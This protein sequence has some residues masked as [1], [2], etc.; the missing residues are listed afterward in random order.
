MKRVRIVVLGVVAI[1]ALHAPARAEDPK[2]DAITVTPWSGASLDFTSEEKRATLEYMQTLLDRAQVYLKVSAP[3]DED[4]RLA[5]FTN[6]NR[7]VGGFAADLQIG[8]DER[9][10]YLGELAELLEKLGKLRDRLAALP[11]SSQSGAIA[12]ILAKWGNNDGQ[13]IRGLCREAG[14]ACESPFDA[15]KRKKLWEFVCRR[16][17]G[18]EVCAGDEPKIAER[19]RDKAAECVG[20]PGPSEACALATWMVDVIERTRMAEEAFGLVDR[21]EP[22]GDDLWSTIQRYDKETAAH[23]RK[24]LNLG[25]DTTP[26]VAQLVPYAAALAATVNRLLRQ[27]ALARRDALVTGGTGGADR[28]FAAIALDVAVAYDRAS[29]YQD[30]FDADPAL[31]SKYDVSFGVNGTYYG[32]GGWTVNGRAGYELSRDPGAVP[33]KRCEPVGTAG[34]AASGEACADALFR[35]GPEPEAEGS[36]YLRLAIGYQYPGASA[37]AKFVPGIEL[38]GGLSDI[39]REGAD[40]T[41]ELRLTL[42]GTPV[43]GDKAARVGVALDAARTEGTGCIVTPIVFVGATTSTLM[44]H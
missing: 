13:M 5:A 15:A 14:L 23:I 34:G 4:T 31:M 39:G 44:A 3:L 20:C 8:Y 28:G 19:A 30:D 38:R 7:L 25:P 42:F 9:A 1:V 6:Q 17:L 29:V 26:T 33:F 22:H 41:W 11:A 10:K 18:A 40:R 27:S 36:A 24:E 12:D 43:E 16:Y 37:D 21:L 2:K 35:A 32:A